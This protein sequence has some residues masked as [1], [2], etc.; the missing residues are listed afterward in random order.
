MT[1][2]GEEEGDAHIAAMR[3]RLR[4]TGAPAAAA[5]RSAALRTPET[6]VTS[7]MKRR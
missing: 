6:S 4:R 5:K 2:C 1:G 7:V 3:D